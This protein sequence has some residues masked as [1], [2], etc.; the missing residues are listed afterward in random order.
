M[1]GQALAIAASGRGPVYLPCSAVLAAPAADR[2]APPQGR[3][4]AAAPPSPDANALATVARLFA[5]AK[6]PLI[7]TANAGRDPAVFAALAAFAERFAIPV[8][9]HRPRY[10]SLPSS[11][12]MNLG[13]D[14]SRLVPK[15]DAILVL[16][17]DV[18]WITSRVA[19]A[20][21]CKVVH[22]GLDPLFTRYPIRGPEHH[23]H[24]KRS[25]RVRRDH[26]ARGRNHS[27]LIAQRR[28]WVADD[29]RR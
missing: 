17:S 8:V 14:P 13:F 1:V 18:P 4:A 19:S 12:P 15:A 24:R 5:Q 9:Q 20:A 26:C 23:D 11:H 21:D 10:F 7:V 22:C 27:E 25:R 29:A 16:E 6:R 2:G 3:L 28:R